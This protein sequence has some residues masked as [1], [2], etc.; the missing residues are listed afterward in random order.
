MVHEVQMGRRK[1]MSFSK[2]KEVIDMPNLIEVQ[3]KSYERFFEVDLRE[4]LND[5][6]PITDFSQKLVLEFVD[7]KLDNNPKYD[8]QQCRERDAT[9]SAPLR[10]KVKLTNKE[11][12]E[13]IESDVFMGE[14]PLMTE[15][16]TFIINGAERV[17]VSQLVR[18]PGAYYGFE[19]DKSGKFLYSGTA[20]PNRGAWLEY[21]TDSNGCVSVRVD[22]TR[23]IPVTVFLR[24][25]GF[26]DDEQ[27][28]DIFGENEYL[29]ATIAKDS[30]KSKEEGLIE[31]YKRLRPGEPPTV[32]SAE[33]LL[34]NLFF[35]PKR[36]DFARVGRYKFNKKLGLGL[37]I[38]DKE[39]AR[40]LVDN[41]GVVILDAGEIVTR[42]VADKLADLAVNVAYIKVDEDK[43]QKV[44]GNGFCNAAP[45]LEEYGFDLKELG[46]N[47][48][49][50]YETLMNILAE[51][52]D[53]SAEELADAIKLSIKFNIFSIH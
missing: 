42:E 39:L 31:L 50:H 9:Y 2:I 17:I 20:I 18:S 16:G 47:E 34:N 24:A 5:I 13:I 38:L 14:F 46:I 11:T 45:F 35:D 37:R 40:P 36:Y 12:G 7:Y 32:D 23:K 15:Q 44:F 33:T 1:R 53:K 26:G 27:L 52:Q 10:V 51:Y 25:L 41:D 49:V 6:S 43:E 29:E 4:V 21:E 22:R 8:V 3:K 30:T 28:R 48:Y 19:R